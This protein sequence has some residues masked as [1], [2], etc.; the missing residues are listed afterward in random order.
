MGGKTVE[1]RL[2]PGVESSLAEAR[3]LLRSFGFRVKKGLGQHFL[4]DE[5]VLQ[6]IVS[7]AELSPRDTVIEV[8]PGLG[9]LTRELAQQAGQV[10][11][12]E[13]DARLI[14]LLNQTLL[15]FSNV[16]LI[17]GDVL[18]IDLVGLIGGHKDGYKVV[19]NLP[20]YIASP[21]L[22]RFLEASPKPHLMVVMVQKEVGEAIVAEP[23]EMS[24]LSV[25][26]QFYGEPAI[27]GQVSAQSFYPP[28]KV[29]SVILRI[30]PYQRPVVPVADEGAFF[31]VVRA[32]FS[33]PR[34]Q[35]HN[36]LAQGLRLSAG[37]AAHLLE[38]SGIDP[39]RRAET[40]TLKEWAA[41]AQY[42]GIEA[43]C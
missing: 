31:E 32:G 29:D 20:Y 6:R 9:L 37:E 14:S 13:L 30:Q 21:V 40:L 22:R 12:I 28:P 23:G 43:S 25:S 7:S 3:R 2:Q 38:I 15:S 1:K 36:S 33:A 17:S 26:V 24:L 39:R 27:V 11:A 42:K 10:I 5:G 35:L 34:K 18:Q 8:G 41:L 4:V 16:N 19:A